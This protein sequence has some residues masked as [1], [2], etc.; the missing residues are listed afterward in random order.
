[1]CGYIKEASVSQNVYSRVTEQLIGVYFKVNTRVP[2][3]SIF[4][5]CHETMQH[6]E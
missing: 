3:E 1:M 6:N 5:F 2:T 4:P